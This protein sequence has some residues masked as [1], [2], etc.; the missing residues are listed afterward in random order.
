MVKPG[1]LLKT[2]P[3]GEPLP[4][5][6]AGGMITVVPSG[7]EPPGPSYVAT[8]DPSSAT[9]AFPFAS[10]AIPQEFTRFGSVIGAG[11]DEVFDTRFTCATLPVVSPPPPRSEIVT[12]IPPIES[13]SDPLKSVIVVTTGYWPDCSYV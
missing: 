10:P 6:E 4:W 5:P 12:A 8:P 9:Q 1:V 2:M 13:V 7:V 3:V 11:I